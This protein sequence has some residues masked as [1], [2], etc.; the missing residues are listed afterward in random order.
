[1]GR[2]RLHDEHTRVRLL[3]AAE[4]L[5]AEG[6]FDAISVRAVAVR[7]DTTTRAVYALFGSKEAFV[8]ALAQRTFMLV[9]ERVAAVPLTDDPGRDL[10]TCAVNGFRLFAL[11]HPDLFRLFFTAQLPR[12]PLS[13]EA[14]QTRLAAYRQLL[15]LVE[16]AHAA[17]LLGGHSIEDVALLWDVLCTGLA[18]RELCGPIQAADGERI[19]TDALTA[20]LVGLGSL[21]EARTA[22]ADDLATARTSRPRRPAYVV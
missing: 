9:M 10:V 17:G 3:A 20:L 8:Q 2:R 5:V 22:V 6:G 7:A 4:Q 1:M 15:Q 21:D 18:M 14:N 13:S 11:E 19:W 12:P 16:R